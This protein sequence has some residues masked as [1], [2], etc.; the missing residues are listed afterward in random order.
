MPQ[1][2]KA[3]HRLLAVT[4]PGR[5]ASL[6]DTPAVAETLPGF[7]V[8]TWL[9]IFVPAKVPPEVVQKVN[10]DIARVLGNPDVK[11]KLA[12]QG[13]ELGT[14]SPEQFARIIRDDYAKWGKVI[15]QAGIKG[16]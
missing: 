15:Q 10:A 12:P 5:V 16:E 6:P 13:I 4:A 8:D 14:N 9:G 3:R 1:S 2:R 11:A 7:A